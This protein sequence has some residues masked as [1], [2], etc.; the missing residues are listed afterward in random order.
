MISTEIIEITDK[1]LTNSQKRFQ[2]MNLT[3]TAKNNINNGVSLPSK[4]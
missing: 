3:K 2:S 1:R 4:H